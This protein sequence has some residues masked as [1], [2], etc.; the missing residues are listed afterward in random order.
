MEQLFLVRHAQTDWNAERR[1]QGHAD[2]PLSALGREQAIALGRYLRD[3]QFKSAF[4][5][6]LARTRETAWL[7]G[8]TTAQPDRSWREFDVGRWS[9][10]LIDDLMASEDKAYFRWRS[11]EHTPPGGESWSAFEARLRASLARL[12]VIPGQVLLVTHS[13]VIRA[14]TKIILGVPAGTLAAVG[15]A[16]VS[17]LD[18]RAG[19]NMERYDV[20]PSYFGEAVAD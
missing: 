14:I 9:G 15:H 17:V 2:R 19:A 18:F 13:G 16:S 4:C 11:G 3:T 12:S 7:A 6:D 5:S 8:Y 10:C 1:L 20:R